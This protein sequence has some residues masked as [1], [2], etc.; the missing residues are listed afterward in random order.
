MKQKAYDL[1]QHFS[2]GKILRFTGP[3]MLTILV[4]SIYEVIDGFYIS[5]FVGET[6]FAAIN[7]IFPYLMILGTFGV[8]LGFGGSAL[9]GKLRG[10]GRKD[11]ANR[12]FS[13]VVLVAFL[14][15]VALAIVG[16]FT[17]KPVALVL[18]AEEG[19][20]ADIATLFGCICMI[21]LPGYIL[22]FAFSV[23]FST[24]GKPSMALYISLISAAAIITLDTI[25]VGTLH[26]GIVGAGIATIV[27]EYIGGLVPF[28]YFLRKNTSHL[29]LVKPVWD[30][31]ALGKSFT[32]GLSEFTLEVADSLIVMLYN[33]QLMVYLGEDGVA[34]FG[35]LE[36][37]F[38][39][40]A[41]VLIGYANGIQPLLSY[42]YGAQKDKEI[43][44]LFSFSVAF[45]FICGLLMLFITQL[46]APLLASIFVSYDQQLYDLTVHAFRIYTIAFSLI[47]FNIFASGYFAALNNG[48]A[49][50]I[51]AFVK[52][53][54]FEVLAVFLLPM[55]FGSDGIWASIIVAEAYGVIMAIFF[56][57][58]FK[59]KY[60]CRF[61]FRLLK[62]G[63]KSQKLLQ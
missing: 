33:Y 52:T 4:V 42:Q 32:N 28:V 15:G 12:V 58:F 16:F 44:Y 29:R 24:A 51:L 57:V 50:A 11:Y 34:A 20:M 55:A 25:L 45:N 5:N 7:I 30:I 27:C 21:S 8:M 14:M 2:A 26:M 59:K 48:I 6:A 18:G 17:M 1:S 19:E 63:F 47:G 36:Y 10:E 22:Q 23:L 3:A 39:L 41:S 9:I 38:Y 43:T 60:Y 56:F 53:F 61:D 31:R 62:A 35:V 13:M 37:V 54:I 46:S 49:A 40:F